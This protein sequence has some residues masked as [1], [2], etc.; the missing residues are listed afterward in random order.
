[1]KALIHADGASSGN[2]GP[3]GIGAVVVIRGQTHEISEP[4]GVATNNVAEY[5]S[6]IR[7]LE[8]AESLGA[9]EAEVYMDSELVVRQ[10]RG[11]Y[12]VK[13]EGLKPLH[14]TALG[15]SGKFS[16]FSISH[17]P[18]EE[19]KEAD[20]LSKKAVEAQDSQAP[21]ISEPSSPQGNLPF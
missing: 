11:E 14:S 16:A 9:S 6:L 7:A 4:I 20:R 2:P 18:R 5:T 8:K 3:A 21:P 17:V 13:N 12:K 10:M 15:L 1:M 19:N